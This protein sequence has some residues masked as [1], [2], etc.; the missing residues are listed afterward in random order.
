[1]CAVRLWSESASACRVNET[2]VRLHRE[3]Q[4][5]NST[6]ASCSRLIIWIIK[7]G[8][9]AHLINS[10][11]SLKLSQMS[12]ILVKCQRSVLSD[13]SHLQGSDS[14]VTSDR[15]GADLYSRAGA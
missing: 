15:G 12:S 13:L 4:I 6:H 11:L 14:D 8:S 7:R 10:F 1:M 3:T 5:N 2:R 9:L